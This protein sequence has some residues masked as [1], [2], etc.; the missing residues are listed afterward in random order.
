MDC[1]EDK[2]SIGA[3]LSEF[4]GGLNT[5]QFRH[6]DVEYDHVGMQARGFSDQR[7]TITDGSYH[8]EVRLQNRCEPVYYRWMVVSE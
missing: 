2:L 3:R 4:V 5:R 6:S 7:S 8:I 1:Q